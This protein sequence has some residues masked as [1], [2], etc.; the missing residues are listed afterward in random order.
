[1]HQ[2]F[3]RNL[4]F[5]S[6]WDSHAPEFTRNSRGAPPRA[7][8]PR[9]WVPRCAIAA[10]ML[11]GCGF[12]QLVDGREADRTKLHLRS[13]GLQRDASTIHG[14]VEAMVYEV[15]VHP[16]L[17]RPIDGLDH[18]PVPFT[19]RILGIVGEVRGTALL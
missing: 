19:H 1:G 16:H 15:A 5:R 14:R 6:G 9:R 10:P 18:H 7:S 2:H 17:D 8:P 12:A 3:R 11:S 13:L 4:R